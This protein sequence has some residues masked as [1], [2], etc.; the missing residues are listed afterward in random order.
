MSMTV[1]SYLELK[2]FE[3]RLPARDFYDEDHK[4]VMRYAVAL[5]TCG[6]PGDATLEK[7]VIEELIIEYAFRRAYCNAVASISHAPRDY[8]NWRLYVKSIEE[9]NANGET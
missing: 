3:R 4:C 5:A 2:Q 7:S 1:H 8:Y 9:F 6:M